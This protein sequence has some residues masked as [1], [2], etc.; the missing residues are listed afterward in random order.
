MANLASALMVRRYSSCKRAVFFSAVVPLIMRGTVVSL[1][2]LIGDY[3][4]TCRAEFRFIWRWSLSS[5]L[6]RAPLIRSGNWTGLQWMASSTFIYSRDILPSPFKRMSQL[7]Y[8]TLAATTDWPAWFNH[9]TSFFISQFHPL[10]RAP[11]SSKVCDVW[12][13]VL[14]VCCVV[15]LAVLDTVLMIQSVYFTISRCSSLTTAI[16]LR[17]LH[18]SEQEGLISSPNSVWPISAPLCG[19]GPSYRL[20]WSL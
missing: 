15:Q 13:M 17:A 10:A 1:L 11:V 12:F 2:V 14:L 3:L 8:I 9:S 6:P 5:K 16:S 4:L 18:A 20:R 19:V 7:S